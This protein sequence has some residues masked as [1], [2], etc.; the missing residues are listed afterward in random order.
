MI[1]PFA[2]YSNSNQNGRGNQSSAKATGKSKATTDE[3][4]MTKAN[5]ISDA[6]IGSVLKDPQIPVAGRLNA[7]RRVRV[8]PIS[9]AVVLIFTYMFGHID[10]TPCAHESQN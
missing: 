8:Y 4:F 3:P 1:D 7:S 6:L 9:F 2:G 5:D 10:G